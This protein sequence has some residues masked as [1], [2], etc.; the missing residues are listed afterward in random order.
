MSAAPAL[1]P[2]PA[3]VPRPTRRLC[4]QSQAQRIQEEWAR[5]LRS[6][7]RSENPVVDWLI[8]HGR[9]VLRLA[10]VALVLGGAGSF[11]TCS[12][13]TEVPIIDTRPFFH[14]GRR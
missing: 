11:L 9:S 8:W 1:R 4:V 2:A 7:W 10:L 13:L 6:S 3:P 14:G 12:I 5:G